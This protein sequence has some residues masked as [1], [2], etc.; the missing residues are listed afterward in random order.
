MNSEFIL[1]N[2]IFRVDYF[3]SKNSYAIQATDLIANTFYMSF[4]DL[5]LVKEVIQSLNRSKFEIIRFPENRK[6]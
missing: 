5:P 1:T 2:F 4:K 6:Y 3:D